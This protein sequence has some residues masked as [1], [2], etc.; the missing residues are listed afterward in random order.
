VLDCA[1]LLLRANNPLYELRTY[2]SAMSSPSSVRN[3]IS[4]NASRCFDDLLTSAGTRSSAEY[5]R[6]V[7]ICCTTVKAV[8]V[9]KLVELQSTPPIRSDEGISGRSLKSHVENM[10]WLYSLEQEGFHVKLIV[11]LYFQY[12]FFTAYY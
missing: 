7:S 1:L 4:A 12:L 3:L 5:A 10:L 11:N 9:R 8:C 6:P 2:T